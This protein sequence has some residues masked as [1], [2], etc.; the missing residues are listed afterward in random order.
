MRF[1]S[2]IWQQSCRYYRSQTPPRPTPLLRQI[3]PKYYTPPASA[4]ATFAKTFHLG[5]ELGHFHLGRLIFTS[6]AKNN[7]PGI[8]PLLKQ[9]D[10]PMSYYLT[11]IDKMCLVENW[12]KQIWLSYRGVRFFIKNA[13]PGVRGE[14]SIVLS[15]I[16]L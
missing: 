1:A 10:T 4:D 16:N 13:L 14:I 6:L 9:I 7:F 2:P 8:N 12:Y 15:S 11:Y 3:E 5:H